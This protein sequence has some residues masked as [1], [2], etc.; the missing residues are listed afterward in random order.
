MLLKNIKSLG[1]QPAADRP[2]MLPT[3]TELIRAIRSGCS[4]SLAKLYDR[5]SGLVYTLALKL[6][7]DPRDAEDLAQ[8]VFLS[9]WRRKSYDPTRGSLS[10]YLTTLTRSRAI[11]RLRQRSSRHKIRDRWFRDMSSPSLPTPF[12]CASMEERREF[13]CQALERLPVNQ[14]R[15]LEM[16][17]YEGRSQSEIAELLNAPLGT[18]KSWARRGLLNLRDALKEIMGDMET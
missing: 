11:D 8:E 10:S 17:Y 16:A 18:V 13:V 7:N 9:L 6:L 1:L 14:R 2:A 12:D 15:V 4:A 5:Y 3:D